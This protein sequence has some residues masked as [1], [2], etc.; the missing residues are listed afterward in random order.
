[1]A[2]SND[3]ISQFVKATNDAKNTPKETTAYGTAVLSDGSYYVK[4]DGSE[5]LT[6]MTKTADV[7][8]GDRVTVLI[9]D[10]QVIVTGNTTSPA[11]RIDTVKEINGKVVNVETRIDQTD[12][13][14]SLVATKTEELEEGLN[15]RYTK[16][17]VDAAIKVSADNINLSVSETYSTKD[18]LENL[19][20][21]ID[22]RVT[23]AETAI[24]QN[25]QQI[26]LKATMTEVN[27]ALEGYYT[28]EEADAEFT[29]T[30]DGI[31]SMVSDTFATKTETGDVEQNLQTQITEMIQT[32]ESF[33][34]SLGN[35]QNS[36]AD[37]ESIIDEL[38]SKV[39]NLE[40]T[41]EYIEIT[42]YNDN[43][44]IALGESDSD[45]KLLI[46]NTAIL[47]YKGDTV[48]NSID[49]EG[50]TT[51]NNIVEGE[52]KQGGFSWVVHGN[53]NLGLVWKGE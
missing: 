22:E 15:D 44:C 16:T 33:Q 23:N 27:T 18:D 48:I 50:N 51:R 8:D 36:L 25:S 43:P 2:L 24:D 21:D 1:M 10:H 41:S 26:A 12:E 35:V 4:L 9:K 46:T 37:N 45:Y 13:Q 38:Q 5:I 49:A 19:S 17:E 3:L 42:E 34:F 47:F 30:S 52:I 28:K 6:P 40:D 14:I 53:G 7:E 39:T 11:A 20:K 31:V 29:I 32:S